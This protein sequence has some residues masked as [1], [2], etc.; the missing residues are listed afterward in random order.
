MA[1]RMAAAP[2][3]AHGLRAAAALLAAVLALCVVPTTQSGELRV[4]PLHARRLAPPAAAAWQ[5]HRRALL[6]ATGA[7]GNRTA[8]LL[9]LYGSVRDNGVFTVVVSLGTPPQRFDVIVDTGSTLAYVPCRD[10]GASCGQHEARGAA[11]AVAT[12]CRLRGNPL[13]LGL[14][15]L[16]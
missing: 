11:R 13:R 12:R 10:C 3:H 6:D 1:R 4:L 14:S 2:R 15:V 9:P 7:G 16:G 5:R 8:S